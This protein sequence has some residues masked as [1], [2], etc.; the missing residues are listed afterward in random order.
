MRIV[1]ESLMLPRPMRVLG[2]VRETRDTVSITLAAPGFVAAPGQFNMLYAFGIG[3]IPVSLSAIDSERGIVVHTI[4]SVGAVSEALSRVHIDDEVFVRGPYGS[5]FPVH[6]ARNVLRVF[7]AGGLGL[8]PLRPAIHAAIADG[9]PIA[10]LIGTRSPSEAL[11]A[12]EVG[13]WR[14]AGVDV[15]VTVDCAEEGYT[16]CVGFVTALISDL[17]LAPQSCAFVCG[18]EVMMRAVARALVFR[19]LAPANVHLAMERSMKCGVGLCG[20]CQLGPV[21]ICKDGPVIDAHRL[22]RLLW[23]QEL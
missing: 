23:T 13:R 1:T 10:V 14:D 6:E 7:V 17:H 5:A 16:G 18:P 15:A 2:I 12:D 9:G 11:Y 19:G 20:H 22:G 21:F 4:R 3:E 8:A